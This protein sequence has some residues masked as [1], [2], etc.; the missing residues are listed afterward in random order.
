MKNYFLNK[1]LFYI[2]I[3]FFVFFKPNLGFAENKF[4]LD[5]SKIKFENK[6]KVKLIAENKNNNAKGEVLSIVKGDKTFLGGFS[7]NDRSKAI[8]ELMNNM[9]IRL[10]LNLRNGMDKEFRDFL[11]NKYN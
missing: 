10:K 4:Y 3:L 2:F 5:L 1:K 7:I 11:T 9:I 6:I 8:D